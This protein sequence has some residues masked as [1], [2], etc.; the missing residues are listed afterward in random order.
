M[1]LFSQR[2]GIGSLEKTVQRASI[3]DELRNRLWSGLKVFIWDKWMP[4]PV[5]QKNLYD[6]H[7]VD[8]LVVDC[9]CNYFKKPID[10]MRGF[11]PDIHSSDYAT[12]RDFFFNGEWWEVYDFIEY[13]LG[14]V[15]VSWGEPLSAT[16][17]QYLEEE[18]A[19]Y[20]IVHNQVVEITNPQEIE[21]VGEALNASSA[22]ARTH[23]ARSLELL[24]DKHQP[25]YRNSIKESISAVETVCKEITGNCK[26]TLGECLKEIESHSAIHP[27]FREALNKLYGYTSDEGGIRHSL[28]ETKSEPSYADA[29]FMLVASAAFANYLRTKAAEGGAKPLIPSSEKIKSA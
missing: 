26:A 19:A 1:A 22:L 16:L 10:T 11:S 6:K 5:Y 21:S 25:D 15:Q 7:A 20:R 24:S 13:L 29:K 23:L 17:N 8:A 28:K 27:A 12:I 4:R 2:L 3:D 9:W 18:N 14:N